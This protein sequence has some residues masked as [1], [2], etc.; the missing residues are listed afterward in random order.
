VFKSRIEFFADFLKIVA[1]EV[2]ENSLSLF[3]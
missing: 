2:L 3:F 1:N